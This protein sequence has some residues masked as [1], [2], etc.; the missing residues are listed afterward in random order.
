MSIGGFALNEKG[1]FK[2]E[3][4]DV[5]A[6]ND[7]YPV[8]HQSG[9]SVI[10]NGKRIGANGD[11]R[12]EQT[13]GQWQPVPKQLS[14]EEHRDKNEI[15]TKLKYPDMDAHLRGFNPMIYP[16]FE[17]EYEV[18]TKGR[19][20]GVEIT[21][22]LDRPIPEE[23]LDKLC[24]NLELFPGELF[25]KSWLMDD[26][27]GLFPRQA[28]APTMKQKSNFENSQKMLPKSG[29]NAS[30]EKMAEKL[31]GYS[32]IIAD[33][34]IALPY[35]SGK[36]FTIAPEEDLL[37]FSVESKSGT[38]S[39]YDGRMNHNNGWFVLS[40][41]VKA[42]VTENAISW[43]IR[44]RITE[45]FCEPVTIQIS[46]VGYHINQPKYAYI[47]L[48]PKHPDD[49]FVCLEKI[50]A[51]KIEKIKLQ[52]A[53]KWGNFLR[54]KYEIFD[55]TDVKEDGLYRISCGKCDEKGNM[56][57]VYALSSV[58]KIASDVYERGVWQPV[59]EYFLPV[60]MCHMRVNEK[61]KVW[62]G[63]CHKDD[64]R[65]SLTDFEQFDGAS[66]ASSTYT[67][68][69]PGDHI[70]G[71]NRGG[72]HDAGDFDL[73]IESQTG[74]MFALSC[75]YEE[76]DAYIDETTIDQEKMI[77]EIHLPDGKNDILQQLE[78]GAL[79][80]IGA[81][82]M[83]GRL[84]HE[85]MCSNL[86]Q[87]VLLGDAST[88]TPGTY[89]NEMERWVFTEDNPPRELSCAADL[90]CSYRA[91]KNFNEDLAKDC[92]R[93]AEEIF[94]ESGKAVDKTEADEN[95]FRWRWLVNSKLRAACELFISTSKDEYRNYILDNMDFI[96]KGIEFTGWMVARCIHKLNDENALRRFE[97]ALLRL[98][99]KIT[100]NS[101]ETPYKIP[102]RPQIWGAGWGIEKEGVN[103]YFLHKA[104]PEIFDS[105]MLFN[106]L[107]FILGCHPGKNTASFVSGVGAKSAT[108]AYGVN[109]S[110]WSYIPGGV[111]SG[112]A[113][114]RPDLPELLEFPYLWQQTEYCLG[115]WS[116]YFAFLV[117]A[118]METLKQ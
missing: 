34:I 61:Y 13:P 55:F 73:R 4:V 116:T 70:D 104:F 46:Q 44:P 82:K 66:Q 17:F 57:D 24:F 48:D 12:F 101:A 14:R 88:M 59:F 11:I 42:G 50:S 32:P 3:G 91:L 31:N 67:M 47:E 87:Y 102:Y 51:D 76:F 98:K 39:L 64:A 71:L 15:V 85:I 114:I 96:V 92:L 10:M 49:L 112:T 103:Y 41:P 33:D 89:D 19:D 113:L 100:N 26:K 74:E 109:R 5:M 68:F 83:L 86:R 108:V 111:I 118:V 58:F 27:S 1:Y 75:L 29:S 105:E 30:R 62:H 97:E 56:T 93:A 2:N 28:N 78:H 23:F 95:N 36:C 69:K 8:G 99:E 9:V 72:W 25:G 7:F 90:A 22:N 117:H 63:C 37:C 40:E 43:I 65:M 20:K 79:S 16:D 54:Y 53:A 107:N 18:I 94:E 110:D 21:V 115:G 81:Y 38:I 77:T 52:K 80:V 35:A 60:Q 84:Y 106:S 45:G 6:F